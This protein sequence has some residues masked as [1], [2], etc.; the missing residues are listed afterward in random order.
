MKPEVQEILVI[1]NEN[2]LEAE[3]KCI[4]F[5]EQTK[6]DFLEQLTVNSATDFIGAVLLFVN[7][8]GNE[9][10][11]WKAIPF[12]DECWGAVRFLEDFIQDRSVLSET[13]VAIATAYEYA[14]Y[15][16]TAKKY[17]LKAVLSDPDSSSVK[18]SIYSYF[19]MCSLLHEDFKNPDI[20]REVEKH[21]DSESI[22]ALKNQAYSDAQSALKS[23]PI[24]QEED[25]LSIRYE[26]EKKIDEILSDSSSSDEPFCVR[27][28]KT[29]QM[30]LK[31]DFGIDWKSPIELNPNIDFR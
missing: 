2:I 5:V 13:C 9:K 8:C 31:R 11:P 4:L 20:S 12:L 14:N 19:L 24:E 1:A 25:F 26:A 15:F 3:K 17:F 6:N 30:V 28:W 16:Q 18:D 22:Q 23:D 7:L 10:K 29:K 27:Y 21:F